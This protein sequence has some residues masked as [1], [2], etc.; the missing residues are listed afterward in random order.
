[1]IEV[2]EGPNHAERIKDISEHYSMIIKSKIAVI[3]E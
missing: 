2:P 1:M 3:F